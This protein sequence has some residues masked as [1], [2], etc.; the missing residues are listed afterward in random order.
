ME[1]HAETDLSREKAG[2]ANAL[3]QAYQRSLRL[4]NQNTADA[5]QIVGGG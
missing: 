4:V 5:S 2:E 1:R 3:K